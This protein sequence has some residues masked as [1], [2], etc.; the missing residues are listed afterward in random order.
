MQSGFYLPE[1]LGFTVSQHANAKMHIG[2]NSV[3]ISTKNNFPYSQNTNKQKR[4]YSL[5]VGCNKDSKS[6]NLNGN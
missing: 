3:I 2:I 1:F 5:I 6:D 4:I